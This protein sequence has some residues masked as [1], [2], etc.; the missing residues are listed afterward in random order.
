MITLFYK[1]TVGIVSILHGRAGRIRLS[2]PKEDKNFPLER[3]R[4]EWAGG[5]DKISRKRIKKYSSREAKPRG[6]NIFILLRAGKSYRGAPREREILILL[7]AGKRILPNRPCRIDIPN[8]YS[9]ASYINFSICLES[10]RTSS[11]SRDCT[12]GRIQFHRIFFSKIQKQFFLLF[13]KNF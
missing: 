13:L 5:Q 3:L 8:S 7:R 9:I 6:R 4:S 12:L 10:L 1:V 11:K 2:S